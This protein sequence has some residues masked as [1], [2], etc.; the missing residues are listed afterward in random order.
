MAVAFHLG[1]GLLDPREPI[2]DGKDLGVVK[3]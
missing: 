3:M 1:R 2:F